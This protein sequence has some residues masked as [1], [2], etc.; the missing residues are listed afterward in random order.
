MRRSFFALFE[1]KFVEHVFA[2]LFAIVALVP[3]VDVLEELLRL[4]RRCDH[5]RKFHR[6][7]TLPVERRNVIRELTRLSIDLAEHERLI[8]RVQPISVTSPSEERDERHDITAV[9]DAGR[10]LIRRD[11]AVVKLL[12]ITLLVLFP[13]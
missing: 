6:S 8:F 10:E 9:L 3:P 7:L 13:R 12:V 11:V 1:A 2:D 5:V 4:R